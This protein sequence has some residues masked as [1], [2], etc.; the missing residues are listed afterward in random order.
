MWPLSH[1]RYPSVISTGAC[2]LRFPLRLGVALAAWLLGFHRRV[3][4]DCD[5]TPQ[6][7]RHGRRF[8]LAP[9]S[10]QCE[11]WHSVHPPTSVLT[12]THVLVSVPRV[13]SASAVL[14][15][16]RLALPCDA[17]VLCILVYTC[18]LQIFRDTD[19]WVMEGPL[20]LH[21]G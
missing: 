7:V 12:H 8:G 19:G 10:G 5:T 9:A 4:P 2:A 13:C 14:P 1:C 16:R 18:N 11:R 6:S 3:M 17:H 15:N 21:N 20:Q